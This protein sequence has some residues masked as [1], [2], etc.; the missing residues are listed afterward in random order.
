M[1]KYF[2]YIMLTCLVNTVSA[3]SDPATELAAKIADRMRDSLSLRSSQRDSLYTINMSLHTQKMAARQQ[4]TASEA[5][6]QATQELE[7]KRDGLYRTVFNNEEKYQLYLSKK[8][9]LISN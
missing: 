5:L 2:A 7:N 6:R 4:H 8:Q 3:Q 9:H 1:K